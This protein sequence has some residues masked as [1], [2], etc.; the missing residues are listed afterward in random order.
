MCFE[1]SMQDRWTDPERSY[2][3]FNAKTGARRISKSRPKGKRVVGAVSGK[4]LFRMPSRLH[5]R[6]TECIWPI[7]RLVLSVPRQYAR[8][9]SSTKSSLPSFEP[10]CH[11]NRKPTGTSD[12]DEDDGTESHI[13]TTMASLMRPTTLLRQTALAS[14]SAAFARPAAVRAA[15]FQ[16][17]SRKSAILPP[18]PRT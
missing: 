14:R 15:A 17:S 12:E 10:V 9:A 5:E 13:T 4:L 16:T 8:L 11:C 3:K 6:L 1:R 2:Q 18:G 7:R